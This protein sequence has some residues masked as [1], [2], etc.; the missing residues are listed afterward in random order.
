MGCHTSLIPELLRQK[1]AD[2]CDFKDS[3]VYIMSS[4]PAR[5]TQR[6]PVSKHKTKQRINQ[7]R[8]YLQ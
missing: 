6:D 7:K 4:S 2:L 5:A 3:P 1:Q 8:N